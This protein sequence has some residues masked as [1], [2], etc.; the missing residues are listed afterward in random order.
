MRRSGYFLAL[1]S[2]L[3]AK[4]W[5]YR[6][7]AYGDKSPLHVVI[8]EAPMLLLA[9][10]L[11]WLVSPRGSRWPLALVYTGFSVFLLGSAGYVAYFDTLV[12]PAVFSFT[13]QLTTLRASISELWRPAYLLFII[14]LPVVLY[15]AVQR[16]VATGGGPQMLTTV[17]GPLVLPSDSYARSPRSLGEREALVIGLVLAAVVLSIQIG[18]AMK[19]PAAADITLVAAARGTA[20]AQ[21]ALVLRPEPDAVADSIASDKPGSKGSSATVNPDETP[22]QRLERLI[23]EARGPVE[24]A[25]LVGFAR[26]KYAGAPIILVQ[27]E[28]LQTMDI[29]G[30]ID[31]HAVTPN[32]SAF[33]KSAYFYP[34]MVPQLSRG[35]T[36]D[37]EWSVN[38]GMNPPVG[39]AACLEYVKK[40]VPGLPRLLKAQKGYTTFTSHA[41]DAAYWN[42]SRLYPALGFGRYY[43][44]AYFGRADAMWSGV[45]DEVFFAKNLE[46]IKAAAEKKTPYYANLVTLSSHQ[47]YVYVPPSRRPLKLSVEQRKTMVGRHLGVISYTDEAF[48]EFLG[49]LKSAGIY[50]KAIIVVIGDHWAI[51][52]K[53]IN[54]DTGRGLIK[55]L[56]GREYTAA[57]KLRVPLMIHLPG[58]KSGVRSEATVGEVDIAPTLADAV[59]LN[60][61]GVPMVGRSAFER[62][63][64]L[65]QTRTGAPGGSFANNRIIYFAGLD[66]ASGTATLRGDGS[67]ATTSRRDE[68]DFERSALLNRLGDEWLRLLP[69]RST[70]GDADTKAVIPN[71]Q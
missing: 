1:L 67:R 12:T 55:Q 58:Q 45:S 28:A 34:N 46:L 4:V 69:D 37:V 47:P 50:D 68:N 62:H 20:V 13:G 6:W 19:L 11:V 22:S 33:A 5:V 18:S 8:L 36:S 63:T 54:S 9:L 53:D 31:G 35:N 52:P 42:R 61:S 17:R 48:G 38:S 14:D 56:L 29:D 65:V 40:Q 2:L 70:S 32:F 49:D 43:D 25:R 44:K 3:A 7:L 30:K 57:D 66:F 39:S 24:G 15:L 64:R 26:G 60:L 51:Q 27:V 10:G 41:N 71:K 16:R 59:G 23:R 21:A